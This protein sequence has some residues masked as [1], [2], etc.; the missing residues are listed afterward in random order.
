VISLLF[1]G[2]SK[3]ENNNTTMIAPDFTLKDTENVTFNLSDY[4]NKKTVILLFMY[5][6]CE[7]CEEFVNEVLGPYSNGMDNESVAIISISVYGEDNETGLRDYAEEHNW[8][9]A[10]GDSD[11]DAEIAYNITAVPKIFIIDKNGL[12]AYSHLD[13]NLSFDELELQVYNAT[14]TDVDEKLNYCPVE[15]TEENEDLV[16]ES[17]LATFDEPEDSNSNEEGL[18]SSLSFFASICAIVII[19]F[20]RR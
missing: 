17:C 11:G 8:R 14:L 7:P 5:I 19:A 9:H 2:E 6:T 16:E 15:I 18:L 1:T 13:S 10:L 4:E 20:R 3:A 12:I